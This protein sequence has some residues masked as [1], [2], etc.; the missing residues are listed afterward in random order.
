MGSKNR[1][2]GNYQN[3][4]ILNVFEF[5]RSFTV[6]RACLQI[7][8]RVLDFSDLNNSKLLPNLWLGLDLQNSF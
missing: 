6:I 8:L 7:I 1:I 3:F 2:L 4:D 5:L